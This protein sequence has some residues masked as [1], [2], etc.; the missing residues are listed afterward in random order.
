MKQS[1]VIAAAIILSGGLIASS[2]ILSGG[3]VTTSTGGHNNAGGFGNN[4][5]PTAENVREITNDDHIRGD[6]NA[7]ISIIEYS[8]YECPFCS[9]LHPTLTRVIEERGDEVNWVYRHF[10]LSNIHHRALGASVAAECVADLGGND[11]FWTFTDRLFLNQRALGPELYNELAV[12]LG[13]SVDRL[14]SCIENS[15]AA[16][17]VAED[18]QNAIDAGGRGTPYVVVVN[19]NGDVFPFSGALPYENIM[20][21]INAAITSS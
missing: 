6:A 2:L 12:D 11:A 18:R 17:K 3:P 14:Q 9:R 20:Q 8:D 19:A 15:N 13:I 7:K 1:Y 10:P 21:I 4:L 16:E 5:S